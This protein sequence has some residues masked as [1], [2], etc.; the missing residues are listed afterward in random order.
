MVQSEVSKE[1][2]AKHTQQQKK[3]LER[4][5][6]RVIKIFEEAQGVVVAGV[7]FTR[8]TSTD[9]GF[10]DTPGVTNYGDPLIEVTLV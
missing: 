3:E 7:S 1:M 5:L 10:D 4:D 9:P 6:W 8:P 2:I